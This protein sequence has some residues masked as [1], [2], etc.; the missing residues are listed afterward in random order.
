[1]AGREPYVGGSIYCATKHAASAFSQSM[2]K[3][4]VDTP[5]RVS[6]IQPGAPSIFSVQ[7][8]G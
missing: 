7:L 8:P 3:E 4:L 2:M 1:V 6:E 5:I